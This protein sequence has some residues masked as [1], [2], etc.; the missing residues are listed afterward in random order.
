MTPGRIRKRYIIAA[1][2]ISGIRIA[3][4]ARQI[5]VSR[6]WASREAHSPGVR[7]ILA[8]LLEQHKERIERLF[9]Q[10]LTVIEEAFGARR[11]YV[12]RGQ[13]VE[14]GP[15]HYARLRAV[16]VFVKL[17]SACGCTAMPFWLHIV[18]SSSR[19]Q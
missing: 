15:D 19:R 13:I 14:S 4:V 6:S 12:R 7:N 16:A 1:A 10:S 5:G 3:H 9:D 2:V 11:V 18:R 8:Q 17:I